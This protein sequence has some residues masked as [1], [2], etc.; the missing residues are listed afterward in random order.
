MA[1]I[2]EYPGRID[3]PARRMP[4]FGIAA[5]HLLSPN[6]DFAVFSVRRFCVENLSNEAA[7]YASNNEAAPVKGYKIA[8]INGRQGAAI[9][10]DPGFCSSL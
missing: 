2:C 4:G 5:G 8:C 10:F 7:P 6:A 9:G 3:V 1:W